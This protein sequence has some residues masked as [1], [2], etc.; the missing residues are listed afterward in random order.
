MY[1]SIALA[2]ALAAVLPAT[3][4]AAEPKA[5]SIEVPTADLDLTAAAGR[6]ELDARLRDAARTVCGRPFV[7]S[8]LDMAK[9]R[10][11]RM[12]T[13]RAARRDAR[14]LVARIAGAGTLAV[15]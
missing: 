1:K 6:A 15:R 7:G 9:R 4:S 10:A 3:A 12:Q 8:N 14:I 5:A 2:A 11:C 13:V